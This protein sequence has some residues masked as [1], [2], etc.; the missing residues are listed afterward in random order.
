MTPSARMEALAGRRQLE[1]EQKAKAEQRKRRE[2]ARKAAQKLL[3]FAHPELAG[4]NLNVERLSEKEG[5]ELLALVEQRYDGALSGRKQK[6]YSGSSEPS[7]ASRT[8]SSAS[9]RRPRR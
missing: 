6:R 5:V 8:C 7:P 3:S 4:A 1:A 2:P 9:A